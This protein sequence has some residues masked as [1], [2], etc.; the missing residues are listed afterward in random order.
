MAA[1]YSVDLRTKVLDF[2][3]RGGKKIEACRLYRIGKDTVFRWL[4]LR[5][6]TGKLN[7]KE[8]TGKPWK[9]DYEKLQ[10][11]IEEKPDS[12]LKE[13]AA[14]CN[15]SPAGIRKA[16]IKLK[17]TRK[18]RLYLTRNVTKHKDKSL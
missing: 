4:R 14:V 7:P 15:V 2:I 10:K 11:I 12:T 16:L 18:K 3:D 8:K 5:T 13:F 6:K 1:A 9:L 17:I